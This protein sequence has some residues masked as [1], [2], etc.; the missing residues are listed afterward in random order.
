L[1]QVLKRL[2]G[3]YHAVK[4]AWVQGHT[5]EWSGLR[6]VGRKIGCSLVRCVGELSGRCQRDGQANLGRASRTLIRSMDFILRAR[7]GREL[8]S[9]VSR[10]IFQKMS[11]EKE[12]VPRR[13]V[14]GKLEAIRERATGT[15]TSEQKCEGSK[16]V[17][18]MEYPGGEQSRQKGQ[19]VK[20]P[21]GECRP[22]TL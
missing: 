1:N 11:S 19:L 18:Q 21:G 9:C 4:D 2:D 10:C 13:E 7:E 5:E 15:V 3:E 20:R 6:R 17:S 14:R 22:I 16:E 8:G 12:E